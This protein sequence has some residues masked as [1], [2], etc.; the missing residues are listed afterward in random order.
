MD[1]SEWLLWCRDVTQS[2]KSFAAA[3]PTTFT[4]S[5]YWLSCESS[6]EEVKL[7]TFIFSEIYKVIKRAFPGVGF[8]AGQPRRTITLISHGW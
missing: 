5:A 2:H 4:H 6:P 7:D 1:A 3:W 8:L